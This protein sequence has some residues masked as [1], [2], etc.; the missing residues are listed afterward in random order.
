MGKALGDNA[1]PERHCVKPKLGA[2][3]DSSPEA[4]YSTP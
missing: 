1:E 2:G 4:S 3:C